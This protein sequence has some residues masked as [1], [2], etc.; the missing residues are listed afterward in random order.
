MQKN[1]FFIL[2]IIFHLSLF[3][4]ESIQ[5]SSEIQ[6]SNKLSF[7]DIATSK[8]G[9]IF[10]LEASVEV[11]YE[12]TKYK[13]NRPLLNVENIKEKISKLNKIVFICC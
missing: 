10:L 9:Q 4:N 6:Y 12:R 13:E 5:F 11:I 3:A 7:A 2:T 1:F 8:D